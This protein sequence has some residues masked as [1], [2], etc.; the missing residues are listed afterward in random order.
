VIERSHGRV[1]IYSSLEPEDKCQAGIFFDRFPVLGSGLVF[2][3][4]EGFK[5]RIYEV[6]SSNDEFDN[7]VL[8]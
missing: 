5:H 1:R 7:W 8:Y 4:V 6:F 3:A 2:A